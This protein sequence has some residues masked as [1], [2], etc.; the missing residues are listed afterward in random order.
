MAR[1]QK[2]VRWWLLFV[3]I[4]V[5]ILGTVVIWISEAGHRQDKILQTSLVVILITFLGILWLLGFSR[6]S[7]RIRLIAFAAVVFS[8]FL[9]ANLFQFKGF[10]GDLTPIFEWRWQEKLSTFLQ[11]PSSISNTEGAAMDYPQ[12]L[13]QNRNGVVTS[14]KLNLDWETHP[15]KLV[16]RRPVGAG[17]SDFAVVENSVITQKQ[18]GDMEAI[19]VPDKSRVCRPAGATS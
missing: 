7:W 18:E 14:I 4:V 17:W 16:W 11:D 15:P 5:A 13:G 9:G 19:L 3:I 10:S 8:V 12:F 2:P 1:S 6:L